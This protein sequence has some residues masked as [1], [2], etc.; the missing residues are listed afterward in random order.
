M[1]DVRNMKREERKNLELEIKARKEV[2]KRLTYPIAQLVKADAKE[3]AKRKE[4][5]AALSEYKTIVEAQDAYGY[6][7]ITDDEYDA[8]C[9]AIESGEKYVEETMTP[10]NLAL[11]I[12][13]DFTR[14]M[15]S[16]IRSL[17][18]ELLPPEEQA[19]R[20][21]DSEEIRE[22]AAARRAVRKEVQS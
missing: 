9:E 2:I 11:K 8:I 7:I 17:E 3:R 15:E 16:E 5:A 12:L 19:K 14:Q 18:F 20:R 21:A 22:R 10:V 6:G 13:R 1:E 4:R